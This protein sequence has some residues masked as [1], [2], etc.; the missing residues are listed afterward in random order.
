MS[1][2]ADKG[3]LRTG[4]KSECLGCEACVNVCPKDA[5]SMQEDAEGF[6]YPLLN[7]ER[8]I[9]CGLCNKVCPEEE[10]PGKN[11]PAMRVF[12]GYI[13]DKAI[14]NQST[15]GG[16]FSAIVEKWCD[17]NYVIFGAVADGLNVHHAYIFDKNQLRA[18]RRSKYSQSVIGNAY[19]D[20]DKFLR[21]GYNVLFSGTPCQIAGL[22]KF[23][24]ARHTDSANLLTVEVVCE[25]VPSPL[26]IRKMDSAMERR[27]GSRISSLDYRYKIPPL[28]LGGITIRRCAKWDYQPMGIRLVNGVAL[29]KDRWFNPFWSIWLNHLISRPS[30]YECPFT[31]AE[32]VAD[33]TLGDLWGVHLYCP[34]LYGGNGGSSV[35]FANSAKGRQ[36]LVLCEPEMFGHDLNLNDALRYQS[37]MRKSIPM[38]PDRGNC[39]ADLENPG[40]TYEEINRRW[41]VK[42]SLKL[43]FNKYIWGNHQKVNWWRLRN[44]KFKT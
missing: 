1:M 24:T 40:V 39:M 17:E 19:A 7:S 12:G 25:G 36:A 2:N 6:R 18:F 11:P 20:T 15:S 3:Y 5:L 13:E 35:I 31:T 9:H 42:P 33:I 43:L 4:I 27:Y 22:Y 41:A 29:K 37:P 10:M 34:E 8:C 28:R 23:L 16:A 32:R 44:L 14:R 26:Y 21:E 30:C 38:N